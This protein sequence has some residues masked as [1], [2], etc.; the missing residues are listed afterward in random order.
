MLNQGPESVFMYMS[1]VCW[2]Y[3]QKQ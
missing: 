2:G 1:A 3:S